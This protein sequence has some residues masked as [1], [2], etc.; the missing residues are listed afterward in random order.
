[1]I[2][3]I[4]LQ[5]SGLMASAFIYWAMLPAAFFFYGGGNVG[6]QKTISGVLSTSCPLRKGHSLALAHQMSHSG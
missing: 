1:M 2:L 5:A 4:K 6:G 3:G